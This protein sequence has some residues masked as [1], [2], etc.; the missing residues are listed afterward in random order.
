MKNA[1]VRMMLK[2]LFFPPFEILEFNK[3]VMNTLKETYFELVQIWND[4]TM[5]FTQLPLPIVKSNI[6]VLNC[7]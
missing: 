3:F 5:V 2:D 1:T 4:V 7:K 6:A